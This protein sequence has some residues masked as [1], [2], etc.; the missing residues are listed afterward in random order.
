[1]PLAAAVVVAAAGLAVLQLDLLD[2]VGLTSS[3]TEPPA[4]APAVLAPSIAAAGS[5]SEVE[6]G[7][8]T[9]PAGTGEA[10]PAE[11]APGSGSGGMDALEAELEKHEVVVLVAYMPDSAVDLEVT[12]E[13]RL[14]AA[15]TKAGFVSVNASREKMIRELATVYDIRDTPTVLVFTPGPQLDNRL[16]GY[17]DQTTVAQAAVQALALAD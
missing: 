17:V 10:T 11:P 14:A 15:D 1:V 7:E 5:A 13:A 12:R 6:L 3:D 16:I 9:M 4:A 8:A 2:K